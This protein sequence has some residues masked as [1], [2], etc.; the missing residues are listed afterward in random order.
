MSR[1]RHDRPRHTGEWIDL[2]GSIPQRSGRGVSH[3]A[4]HTR[5]FRERLGRALRQVSNERDLPA[6]LQLFL[7]VGFLAGTPA[8]L[9]LAVLWGG[10]SSWLIPAGMLAGAVAGFTALLLLFGSLWLVDKGIRMLVQRRER[11]PRS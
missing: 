7:L 9:A 11:S 5:P 8:S 6:G 3:Q 2:T 1:R 4:P 10:R